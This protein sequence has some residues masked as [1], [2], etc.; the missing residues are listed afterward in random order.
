MFVALTLVADQ[1]PAPPPPFGY[2]LK[3]VGFPVILS[4]LVLGPAPG[5]LVG[6]VSDILGYLITPPGSG[7]YFPGFTLTQ[8]LTGALPALLFSLMH[9]ER[10]GSGR[11]YGAL[12]GPLVLVKLTAAILITKLLCSVLLVSTFL[13][14][15]MSKKSFWFFAG[16]ALVVAL[17]HCPLYAWLSLPLMRALRRVQERR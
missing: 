2:L 6:A 14:L 12:E 15:F 1:L 10:S 8:G 9:P 13:A 17:V 16:P 7:P 4:G 3:F 5:F 11:V